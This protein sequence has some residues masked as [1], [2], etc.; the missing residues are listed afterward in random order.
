MK[1]TFSAQINE[2]QV[3]LTNKAK[4]S[5]RA[6]N[7]RMLQGAIVIQEVAQTLAPIDKGNLE[8][9]IELNISRD[10]NGR[11]EYNVEI[12]ISAPG[13]NNAATVG[14]YIQRMYFGVYSLG[15]NSTSKD[16]AIGGNGLGYGFGGK[17]GPFF[18]E[19]AFDKHTANIRKGVVDAMRR[20][21]R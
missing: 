20:G 1:K 8:D 4:E 10:R 12:N 14:K 16:E 19:R 15:K 21:L 6:G 11:N 7:R 18:L 13:S 5:R 9:A 3:T 2:L 17:V